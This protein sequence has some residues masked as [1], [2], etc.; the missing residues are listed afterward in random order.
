MIITSNLFRL[1]LFHKYF[2]NFDHLFVF[3]ELKFKKE[4]TTLTHA[5]I[6]IESHNQNLKSKQK[7]NTKTDLAF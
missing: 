5:R 6:Y 7:F 1:K 3:T 2:F 4:N